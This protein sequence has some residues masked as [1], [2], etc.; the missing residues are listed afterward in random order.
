MNQLAVGL[1]FVVWLIGCSTISPQENFKEH[2]YGEIGRSIDNAPSYSWRSET[3]LVSSSILPNGNI[4]NKYRYR[5]TCIYYF[6]IDSKTRRIVS[7]RY[8]G[9]EAD[10]SVNP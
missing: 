1:S 6:E 7:A 10:C 9:N 4:E 8:E 2:I 3:H 5:K